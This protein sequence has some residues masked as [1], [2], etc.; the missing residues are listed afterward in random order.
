MSPAQFNKALQA[1]GFVR[2]EHP[3]KYP[4]LTRELVGRH[5]FVIRD[6][7][8][9]AAWRIYLGYNC[10]PCLEPQDSRGPDAIE[11]ESP[12]FQYVETEEKGEAY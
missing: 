4:T 10:I 1:L 5:Q 3:L 2:F 12:W 11:A 7:V 6:N 8:R 9:G